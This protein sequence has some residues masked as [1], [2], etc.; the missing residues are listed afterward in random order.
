MS[1]L[2]FEKDNLTFRTAVIQYVTL[3]RQKIEST[4]YLQD[5]GLCH[6]LTLM[7]EIMLITECNSDN[8]MKNN[9]RN[10]IPEHFISQLQQSSPTAMT[11]WHYKRGYIS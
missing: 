6:I 11:Q 9:N 1:V 7:Q 2:Q 8:E 4:A 3:I 10:A 5:R